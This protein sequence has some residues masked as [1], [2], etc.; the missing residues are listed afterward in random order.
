[1]CSLGA[2]ASQ[3]SWGAVDSRCRRPPI[4]TNVGFLR[5]TRSKSVD[6]VIPDDC[7]QIGAE[8]LTRAKDLLVPCPDPGICI[9]SS[10]ERHT[11]PAAFHMHQIAGSEL[12]V[13]LYLQP[14]T[15]WF[16][17]PIDSALSCP[18]KGQLPPEFILASDH[19]VLPPWRP[20][21]GTG[22]FFKPD[23]DPV[24]VPQSHILLEAYMRLYARDCGKRVGSFAMAMIA[25]MEL[26]VEAD[27]LLDADR[28]PEPLR[29]FYRELNS[30][31]KP[32]R[33]WTRELKEAL[34]VSTEGFED[35]EDDG[36]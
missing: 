8:A 22:V 17:A 11:P 5:L 21:R 27:G 32:V 2:A 20:G 18:D 9:A 7:L 35:S 6:F 30:G 19:T 10:P 16:L 4:K 26:Y 25:Y 1:M 28:L 12:F 34:G 36:S 14:A 23:C 15:L 13:G 3:C 31:D 33:R 29:K 24:V